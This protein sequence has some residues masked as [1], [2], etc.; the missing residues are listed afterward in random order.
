MCLEQMEIFCLSGKLHLA[1]ERWRMIS[2]YL[3]TGNDIQGGRESFGLQRHDG[4]DPRFWFE[5]VGKSINSLQETDSPMCLS[6]YNLE[7]AFK[8]II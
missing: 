4:N 6:F 3:Y 7:M 8:K 2:L 5:P 1:H